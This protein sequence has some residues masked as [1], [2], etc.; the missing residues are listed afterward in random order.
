M[1]SE[2]QLD[3][4]KEVINIGIGKA[5]SALSELIGSK[6]HLKV[7]IVG[8]CPINDFG[9]V[10]KLEN[11]EEIVSVDQ[12]FSGALAGDAV[13]IF[14]Q[15]SGSSLTCELCG[16]E[17]LG[18]IA[19]ERESALLEVGNIILNGVLGSMSNIFNESLAFD[20]PVYNESVLTKLI[21]RLGKEPEVVTGSAKA[22]FAR[23]DFSISTLQVTGNVL[24]I[25]EINSFEKLI[26]A[27]DNYVVEC[28][29]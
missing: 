6:V 29:T 2:I 9:N 1:L 13:L 18:D 16:E 8:T 26:T 21:T 24:L 14:P 11:E 25:F 22:L 3:A 5:G 27:I 12:G 7:P 19:A 17:E 28:T 15:D 23:A 10:L 20:L 4:L